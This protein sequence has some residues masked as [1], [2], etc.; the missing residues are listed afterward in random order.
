LVS[1]PFTQDKKLA[2]RRGAGEVK[3][4]REGEGGSRGSGKSGRGKL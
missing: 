4:A 2:D 1:P 3:G